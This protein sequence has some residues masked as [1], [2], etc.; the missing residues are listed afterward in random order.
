MSHLIREAI[1]RDGPA[2]VYVADNSPT[3]VYVLDRDEPPH[4][5]LR[6]RAICLALLRLATRQLYLDAEEQ[7]C[8]E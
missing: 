2:L 5:P 7:T 8:Q 1:G 4:L 3:T 6:D